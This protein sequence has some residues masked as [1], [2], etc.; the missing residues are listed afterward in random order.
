MT[1]L[2]I[3]ALLAAATIGSNIT[4][5]GNA[6]GPK[7]TNMVLLADTAVQ[8]LLHAQ[9]HGDVG[10]CQRLYE[11]IGGNKG[12]VRGESMKA[13][14]A[15]MSPITV[16]KGVWGLK[17]KWKKDDFK[18]QDAVNQPFWE[19]AGPEKHVY[20]TADSA[21]AI[22]KGLSKRVDKSV[23]DNKFKGDAAKTKA[24]L[25]AATNALLKELNAMNAIERGEVDPIEETTEETEETHDVTSAG[26]IGTVV[27]SEEA[28]VLTH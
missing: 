18:M 2:A 1:K 24:A 10:L 23:E 25:N 20:F 8:V 13:W 27:T 5:L 28:G 7:S 17:A 26:V 14:F 9:E 12:A 11:S 22:L 16:R 4:T 21:L 3:P 15:A 6:L 19:W